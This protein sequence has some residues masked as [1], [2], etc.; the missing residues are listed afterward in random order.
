[1]LILNKNKPKPKNKTGTKHKHKYKNKGG[2][3]E[4]LAAT[5]FAW[6]AG[7]YALRYVII[8]IGEK[9]A[10]T[11][12]VCKKVIRDEKGKS[13]LNGGDRNI[14]YETSGIPG[15]NVW[16]LREEQP[17]CPD[18]WSKK[19]KERKEAWCKKLLPNNLFNN[20]EDEESKYEQKKITDYFK[21]KSNSPSRN[22]PSRNSPSRNSPSRN[23]PSR[24]S[25]S[26]NSPSRNSSPKFLDGDRKIDKI[27]EEINKNYPELTSIQK[28]KLYET[29]L[30]T[31]LHWKTGGNQTCKKIKFQ[32]F[33][34]GEKRKKNN[35]K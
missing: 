9:T 31:K 17:I 19:V 11:C 14:R 30:Q 7:L 5:C 4:S 24:N 6:G 18:C 2:T 34:V 32:K 28:K 23:S 3:L 1:M 15:T 33:Q 22:S 16:D 27:K 20:I 25:P 35:N 8:K 13:L 29:L 10:G 26:R 12:K 21:K